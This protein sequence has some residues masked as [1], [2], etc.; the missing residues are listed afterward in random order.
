MSVA[1]NIVTDS[2]AKPSD[3]AVST[4]LAEAYE[5]DGKSVE[6]WHNTICDV[7]GKPASTVVFEGFVN[8][9]YDVKDSDWHYGD[10]KYVVTNGL[11]SGIDEKTFAPDSSLTPCYACYGSLPCC[12]KRACEGENREYT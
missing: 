6:I 2:I 12:G 5:E 4:I 9:F 3:Y 8:P 11:F 7:E 1:G 10:V